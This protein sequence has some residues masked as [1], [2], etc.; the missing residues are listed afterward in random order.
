MTTQSVI[1]ILSDQLLNLKTLPDHIKDTL[2]G[3]Q[4]WKSK[5]IDFQKNYISG[6]PCSPSRSSTYTGKDTNVTRISDNT[7]NEWQLSMREASLDLPTLGTYFK[8][9]G[10]HTRYIGKQ[11]L[12]KQLD[13]NLI[14]K[15]KP[16]VSTRDVMKKYDF[17]TYDISGDSGYDIHGAFFQDIQVMERILPNGNM[18]DKCDLYDEKTKTAYDGA[19]P[20]LKAHRGDDKFLC[21]INFQNPH[22]ITFTN[23]IDDVPTSRVPTLQFSGN[24]ANDFRTNSEYN[25]NFRKYRNEELINEVSN[26]VDNVMNSQTNDDP[27]YMAKAYFL[28]NKYYVYG[29]AQDNILGFQ[30]YQTSYLQMI[31]QVDTYLEEL[32]DFLECNNYFKTAVIVLT[33]DHGDLNSAHGL[34]GKGAMIYEQGWN[35][36]LFISY[37]GMECRGE[38]YHYI[39]SNIQAV[40]TVMFLSNNYSEIQIHNLGLYPSIFGCKKQLRNMDFVN[41]KLGLSVG[42][43]P[44]FLP[45]LRSLQQE[46]INAEVDATFPEGMNYFTIPA[47]S[48]SANIRYKCKLY[49]VGYYFSILN[50]FL[51]NIKRQPFNPVILTLPEKFILYNSLESAG[52]AFVGTALQIYQQ[53][54]SNVFFVVEYY[55]N[56]NVQPFVGDLTTVYTPIVGFPPTVYGTEVYTNS[57]LFNA[58]NVTSL[59]PPPPV[60]D[61][62]MVVTLFDNIPL[63]G[64]P[65]A[66]V[67][68]PN[69]ITFLKNTNPIVATW[70]NPTIVAGTLPQYS[71]Y[72]FNDPVY[73]QAMI[74]VMQTPD[75]PLVIAILNLL[76]YIQAIIAL[77]INVIREIILGNISYT[78]FNSIQF[79]ISQYLSQ[80]LTF[81][82]P[83]LDFNV[84]QL[85]SNGYQVQVFNNTC[86]PD[87]LYNLADSRRIF[88]HKNTINNLLVQLYKHIRYHRCE[89]IFVSLPRG[90]I[91]SRIYLEVKDFVQRQ[92]PLVYNWGILE[93]NV[94]N[95]ILD[96]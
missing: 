6:I 37:P 76:S 18:K 20:Y 78:D 70:T 84:D 86:D 16:T 63:N 74:Y 24:P 72:A 26:T 92:V 62:T 40:P 56:I 44:L 68:S 1:F 2:H 15:Y 36:P 30:W 50:M 28:A 69:Y 32:Y 11:H 25:L 57:P 3:Y 85:L 95:K 55:R 75:I 87:E 47:L 39:T 43:G 29:I 10:Y 77:P 65:Y 49:N 73:Q 5:T 38:E 48:I 64:G 31:K 35:T 66:Y 14:L 17:D 93:G 4:K 52:I 91:F 82:T 53:L 33:S 34:V 27:L 54:F 58:G 80:L 46:A 42:Y 67:G 94:F 12:D 59:L 19:I 8:N 23:V 61:P 13:R 71:I 41:L 60:V 51:E 90:V 7:N 81:F 21:V 88:K 79:I 22:D 89:R 83:G 45:L 9:K 96:G